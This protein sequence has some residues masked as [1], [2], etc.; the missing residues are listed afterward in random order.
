MPNWTPQQ[1]R[2]YEIRR[3]SSR[4]KPQP[5]VCN[6]P[7]AEETGKGSDSKRIRISVSSFR[8]K[9]CD[10][11]NLCPKYFIDCL[12]YAQIIKDDNPNEITLEVSQHKVRNKSDERTEL[13]I[14]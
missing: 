4:A 5:P 14:T 6:E 9:L 1:Q 10:P 11:D 12:R 13:E 3:E 2:E 8:R 7:V